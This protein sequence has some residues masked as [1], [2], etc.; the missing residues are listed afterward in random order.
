MPIIAAVV[1]LIAPRILILALWFFSPWFVG[2]FDSLLLA[3]T[4]AH[5][6]ADLATLV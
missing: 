5:L 2:M 6:R 1:A 3:N 4:R